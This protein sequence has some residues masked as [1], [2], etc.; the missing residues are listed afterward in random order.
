MNYDKIKQIMLRD[1]PDIWEF[2]TIEIPR[3]LTS[4]Q[5]LE[6]YKEARLELKEELEMKILT[7]Q[8]HFAEYELLC[9]LSGIKEPL[10]FSNYE[11]F[12]NKDKKKY[13]LFKTREGFPLVY[14][15]GTNLRRMNELA[16]KRGLQLQEIDENDYLR[17][18]INLSKVQILE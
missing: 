12:K 13:K 16:N 1:N 6:K 5:A 17:L 18:G 9:I 14:Y 2:W 7:E 4:G 11:K 10:N 3:L 8:K 15:I